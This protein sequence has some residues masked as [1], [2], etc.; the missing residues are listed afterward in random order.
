MTSLTVRDLRSTFPKDRPS[1]KPKRS[2]SDGE[3]RA[4]KRFDLR[5]PL[6]YR[7]EGL[8]GAGEVV[9]ISSGGVLFSAEADRV[10]AGIVEMHISWPVLLDQSVSLNLVAVGPVVRTNLGKVAVRI[11]KYEFRTAKAPVWKREPSLPDPRIQTAPA[12]AAGAAA[13]Y[14]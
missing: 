3:R 11:N 9:N 6:R 14:A 10:P 8:S 12:R 2:V 7:A 13:F 4:S 1:P 5:L